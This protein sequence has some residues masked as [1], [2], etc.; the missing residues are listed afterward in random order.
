MT[1]H[2]LSI[3]HGAV[4]EARLNRPEKKNALTGVMYDGI[5]EMLEQASS[6][7]SIRAVLLTAE[8]STGRSEV[9]RHGKHSPPS[10]RNESRLSNWPSELSGCGPAKFA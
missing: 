5:V 2:V 10:L 4:L 6:S 8:G 3:R 1:N 9:E 7:N